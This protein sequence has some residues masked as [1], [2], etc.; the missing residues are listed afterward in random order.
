VLHEIGRFKEANAESAA[1]N[2]WCFSYVLLAVGFV[3]FVEFLAGCGSGHQGPPP[4]DFTV[5]LSPN[6]TSAVVGDTTSSVLISTSPQNGFT[7][8]INI[9]LQGIPAGV[10]AM[11]AANFS[12]E[13]GGSQSI[14]FSVVDSA[15]VGPSTITILATSGKLSHSAQL[16]LT[17]EAMVRTYQIGSVLYLESGTTTDKSRIGLET[18]WGGSIVEVSVNGTNYVNAPN[19]GREVQPAFY[20]SNA[21]YD[22]CSGCTLDWGW[23]PVLAGDGYNHATPTISQT[24]TAQSIYTKAQPL[25][26]IPEGKGGGPGVPVLS[27]VLVEQTVTALANYPHAFQVHC[28]VTHLGSDLHTDATQEFPAV[29]V[30]SEYNRFVYYGGTNPWTNGP[31][32]VTQFQLLGDPGFLLYVP[33]HWG[34]HVNTQNVGLTIYVPS[35]YPYVSGFDSPGHGTNYFLPFTMLTFGPNFTFED[36]FYAIAG[37]YSSARQIV[38]DLHRKLGPAPNIFAALGSTDIPSPGSTLSG[39]ASVGGWAFANANLVGV[40]ILV[41]KMVDGAASYGSARPGVADTFFHAPVNIGFSYSL[42]TTRYANGPHTLNVRVTD[43][44]GNVSVFSDVAVTIS[45]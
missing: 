11:P 1:R 43:A 19:T 29:Y 20:D 33:E 44:T 32:S 13:A 17:A 23:N 30:N 41:D 22:N 8:T 3:C 18:A 9:S 15:A 28:K 21:H 25:Q 12:A 16:T 45:N 26:W 35:Q 10:N 34:A 38:Y 7:G 2:A 4:P 5:S 37:D 39:I 14:T 27:D 24:L 6:S 40:E 36:D 42:D 31:V